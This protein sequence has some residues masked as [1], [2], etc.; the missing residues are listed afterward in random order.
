VSTERQ[1]DEVLARYM[2]ASDNRDGAAQA[3]LFAPGAVI[4][5]WSRTMDG[6][7]VEAAPEFHAEDIEHAVATM[8]KPHPPGG[9]SHHMTTDHIVTVNGDKAHISAQFIVYEV[10]PAPEPPVQAVES[11]FFEMDLELRDTVWKIV[12]SDVKVDLPLS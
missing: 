12:R 1:I 2:R 6:R 9:F 4:Q 8:I 5:M 11:G 3:A 10:R 7:Y